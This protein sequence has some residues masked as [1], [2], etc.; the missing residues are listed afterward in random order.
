MTNKIQMKGVREGL[1]VSLGDG[2]WSELR[3]A[4]LAHMDEQV[5]FLRGAKLYL[6]VGNQIL[7]AVELGSLRDQISERGLSLWGVL[8]NSPT[9]EATAQTLG[10]ATRLSQPSSKTQYRASAP[11]DTSLQ[12]GEDAIVLQRTLRSGYRVKY[13]GHVIVVGDVNPGAEIIAGGSVIVW[14]RLR[15]LV[16]AGASGNAQA[17]V[18]A[19]DL[20]PTQ[21]RIADQ[22]AAFPVRRGKSEPDIARLVGKEV[23][24]EAWNPGRR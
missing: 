24:V 23:I 12:D 16:H 20:S 11:P 19:L 1:L 15:G 6:E 22:V 17:V 21:L 10:L 13:D 8:S 14:G 2:E 5:N 7:N 4:L 3:Q 9:T 18:C